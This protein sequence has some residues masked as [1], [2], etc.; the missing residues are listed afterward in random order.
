MQVAYT[1]LKQRPESFLL[2]IAARKAKISHPF[3]SETL[4]RNADPRCLPYLNDEEQK[5]FLSLH[6][7][8]NS[9][10][11]STKIIAYYRDRPTA[12][13]NNFCADYFHPATNHHRLELALEI[14]PI[15]NGWEH[16][17]YPLLETRCRVKV[18]EL[19][20]SLK[21]S[22]SVDVR[23]LDDLR[24]CRPDAAAA[25]LALSPTFEKEL[26]EMTEFSEGGFMGLEAIR[27]KDTRKMIDL[28]WRSI[29]RVSQIVS[30]DA[31]GESLLCYAKNSI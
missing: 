23:M 21:Y 5:R 3:P 28:V 22:P 7:A 14:F 2:A 18:L 24:S 17:L 16:L 9:P 20:K 19:L 13:L 27:P 31:P 4:I 12:W 6:M 10:E 25:R 29:R 30:K 8:S 1:L 26:I 11:L 15:R